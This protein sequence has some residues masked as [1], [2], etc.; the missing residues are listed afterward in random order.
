MDKT[1]D[2]AKQIAKKY[3]RAVRSKFKVKQALLFGSAARGDMNKDSDIDLC[4]IKKTG[5]P[6]GEKKEI[7]RLFFPRQYPMDILVWTPEYVDKRVA[8]GDFFA[9]KIIDKGLILYAEK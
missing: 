5:D 9:K 6:R 4:V 7:N 8:I 2:S 3:L 1:S